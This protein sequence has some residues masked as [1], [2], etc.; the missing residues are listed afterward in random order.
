MLSW[1]WP[2][3]VKQSPRVPHSTVSTEQIKDLHVTITSNLKVPSLHLDCDSNTIS[4]Y[5][6]MPKASKKSAQEEVQEA[7]AQASPPSDVK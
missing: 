3:T 5:T 1:K 7:Q 6:K 2:V 4:N